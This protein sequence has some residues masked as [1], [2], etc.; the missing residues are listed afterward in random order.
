MGDK[1]CLFW[2]LP[3]TPE[4]SSSEQATALNS[5]L[6]SGLWGAGERGSR[7]TKGSAKTTTGASE[8]V[9]RSGPHGKEQVLGLIPYQGLKGPPLKKSDPPILDSLNGNPCRGGSTWL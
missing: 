6:V 8:S 7:L 4:F 5:M 1:N 2:L 9:L 3:E